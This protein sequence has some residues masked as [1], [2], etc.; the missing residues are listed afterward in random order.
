M[1]SLS[2]PEPRCDVAA[3]IRALVSPWHP[4]DAVWLAQ[5]TPAPQIDGVERIAHEAGVLLTV[6]PLKAR[7]FRD[8]PSDD[9]LAE[10]LGYVEPKGS[11]TE[12]L[13]VVQARDNGCVVIEMAVSAHRAQEAANTAARHGQLYLM[14]L[15]DALLRRVAL[16]LA[17]AG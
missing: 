6:A 9:R 17:E 11:V 12:P 14:T 2:T 13:I 8:D 1:I 10:I 7:R 15:P 5:G 3:Q 4:K 16:C